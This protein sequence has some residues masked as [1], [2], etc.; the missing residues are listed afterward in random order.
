MFKE[1]LHIHFIGIGGVG[2]SGIAFILLD[3]G[4]KVSGSDLKSSKITDRLRQKGVIF[5]QGHHE[6]NIKNVFDVEVSIMKNKEGRFYII[7]ES[8]IY[9]KE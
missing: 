7:P 5:Y 9:C 2:M 3:L 4:H 6:D 1:K 8:S